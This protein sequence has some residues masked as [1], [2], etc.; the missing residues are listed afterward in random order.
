[1]AAAPVQTAVRLMAH[2]EEG[3][4][5][6]LERKV[7]LLAFEQ[8]LGKTLVAIKAFARLRAEGQADALLVICP[9]SLKR[10]WLI[11]FSHFE[12]GVE[13]RII[14]G[15]ARARR[16][17]LS[18]VSTPVVIISYETARAEVAG[19]LALVGRRRTVLVLDESHAVKNRFSLTS[20]AARHFAPRCEYRWLL[21]GT[22]VPNTAADLY[23]QIGIVAAGRPLGAFESFMAA[24]GD[25]DGL[26]ALRI[27]I[28][29]YLLRRTKDEC[30]DLPEKTVV[31]MRIELPAWQRHLY[32]GM[33]DQ[34]VCEVRTMS[35]EQ[36]RAYAP[37][38]LAKL[39]RL[40][41]LASN[42]ALLVPTEP[43]VP[44]KFRELDYLLDEIVR[45][46]NEKV[47]IWSHY[48]ETLETLLR[49]YE[50]LGTV[51]LYGGTPPAARQAT[52]E[53]FQTDPAV[54][55]LIGN[56]AA[57]GSGFTL[58][59]ARYAIYETLSWRYD[60]YAQSRDRIHRIGQSRPVAYIRLLAAD[61]IE[62][63][64][65]QALE[66]KSQLASALLGDPD[67]A[68]VISALSPEEFCRMLMDNRLPFGLPGPEVPERFS[69]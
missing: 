64:I 22:P 36:F 54:R 10:N 32:D 53:R 27:R 48:V 11:E 45:G 38:A 57:G 26:E 23:A 68:V 47:I 65:A 9:N 37:T 18:E 16:R 14:E 56:P 46:S 29:P 43:R 31:D 59:A 6:L 50:G 35:G 4:A 5:F 49:R 62:E 41:Q 19:V 3:I 28:A 69:G 7:G 17:A 15:P 21:S 52:V 33:R 40:S 55:V 25:H 13:V 24:Y 12:P 34:L 67:S 66:R 30:L 60:F 63:V 20:T 39:L 58:T 44:A 1:M 2:Q 42:P 61:T 51:A 8:G